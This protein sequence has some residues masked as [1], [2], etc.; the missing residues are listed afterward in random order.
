MLEL[1]KQI[2]GERHFTSNNRIIRIS[3]GSNKSQNISTYYFRRINSWTFLKSKVFLFY[4]T[5]VGNGHKQE[6]MHDY[7]LSEMFCLFWTL[8]L[9]WR[10]RYYSTVQIF[11]LVTGVS[12]GL[13]FP[14]FV[15]IISKCL[16]GIRPN[17]HFHVW[18]YSWIQYPQNIYDFSKF[19]QKR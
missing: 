18:Q 2:Q 14:I 8:V 15:P 6:H 19:S 7:I 16:L 1:G 10:H 17:K 9:C 11:L 5:L 4:K 13:W 12:Q 3:A